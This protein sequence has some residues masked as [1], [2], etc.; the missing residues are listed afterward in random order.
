MEQLEPTFIKVL[1]NGVEIGA[2][3]DGEINCREHS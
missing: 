3:A 1:K 2:L